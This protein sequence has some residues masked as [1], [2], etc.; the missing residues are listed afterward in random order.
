M[1]TDVLLSADIFEN[2]RE[3]CLN[4][5]KL[6]PAHYYT[7]PGLT[8]DAMLKRT[9]IRLEL[10]TDV[11]KLM[12]VERG[13]R[14]GI[15]QCCNRY[16]KSNNP[17]LDAYD[18]NQDINYLV[19][20]DANNL[21][22]WAMT[23]TL[24]YGGFEWVT[25][26]DDYFNF[27]ISNH[28]PVGYI[29]EVYL[30]YPG[31]IHDTHS[32]LPFCSENSKPSRSIQEKLLTTLLPK[33]KYVLHYRVLKQALVNGHKLKKIHPVLKFKQ[34]TWLKPYIDFNT[35]RRANAKNEFEENLFKLMNNVVYG[36]TMENVRKHVNIKLVMK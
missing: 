22:G 13:I 33:R 5:Y 28:S 16:A 14:G 1:K 4:V 27:Y 12:F 6:D 19:Y 35:L 29:L 7:T 23:Q 17:Y 2:F 21:Y 26:V 34:S 10:L 15:S 31:E 3:Q 24:P 9:K 30:D 8:W 20:F 18:E 36:K 32:D 25:N 11:D